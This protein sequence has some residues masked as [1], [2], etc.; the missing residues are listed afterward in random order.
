[1]EINEELEAMDDKMKEL[2]IDTPAGLCHYLRSIPGQAFMAL[3]DTA[4]D[5][6]LTNKDLQK[7]LESIDDRKAK[8]AFYNLILAD[9]CI[10]AMDVMTMLGMYRHEEKID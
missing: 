1:M 10:N 2:G 7:M 6:L 3:I 4:F 8:L 9:L 5:M